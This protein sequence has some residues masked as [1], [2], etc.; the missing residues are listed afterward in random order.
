MQHGNVIAGGRRVAYI[1]AGE[2]STPCLFIHGLAASS[3]WWTDI[4]SLLS[5]SRRTVAIDLPGFGDS[6]GARSYDPEAIVGVITDVCDQLG[7]ETIDIVGHSLGTLLG[8]EFAA[9]FPHRVRRLV[10]VGGPITSVLGL[11][12]SP[13][14]A[15]RKRPKV[16]NFLIEAA[17]TGLPLPARLGRIIARIPILRTIALKPYVFN[18]R[19]LEPRHAE[20][21]LSGTG[22]RGLYPTLARAFS[23]DAEPA[24][25]GVSCPTL[26]L[27]GTHDNIAPIE[28]L[29]EY[30]AAENVVK[31]V[32]LD[33]TGHCPMLE[34]PDD[35]N[36]EVS[37]FLA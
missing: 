17:T 19:Q 18:P 5:P 2:G 32:A 30:A 21:M 8:T 6:E 23:Y 20:L 35:F 34:R 24:M 12:H 15:L 36:R 31:F 11:M 13:L 7:L 10:L 14:R 37:E 16:A 25:A 28:D 3:L 27:G 4:M 26:V 1:D 9:R 22:A 33:D 29:E